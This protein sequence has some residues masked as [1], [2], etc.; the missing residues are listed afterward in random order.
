MVALFVCVYMLTGNKRLADPPNRSKPEDVVDN[1][2]VF[3]Y[4]CAACCEEAVAIFTDKLN[5][6]I[7]SLASGLPWLETQ[8]VPE[9]ESE[10]RSY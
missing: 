4:H 9:T 6:L 7:L 8:Q 5:H 1:L 3:L 2:R 10:V